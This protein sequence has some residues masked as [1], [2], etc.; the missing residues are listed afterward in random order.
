MHLVLRQV[1]IAIL[2][3]R[4]AFYGLFQRLDIS[5]FIW[6]LGQAGGRIK[7]PSSSHLCEPKANFGILYSTALVSYFLLVAYSYYRKAMCQQADGGGG[8]TAA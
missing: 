4:G 1:E 3:Q 2:L 7:V 6:H 5:F 8:A